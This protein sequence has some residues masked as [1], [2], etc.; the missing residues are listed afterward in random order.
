RHFICY[1]ELLPRVCLK[2]A[3]KGVGVNLKRDAVVP[4][5][6][7]EPLDVQLRESRNPKLAILLDVDEFM[8]QE[9]VR[10]RHVRYHRIAERDG[11]HLGE[12]RQVREAHAR[13]RK[14]TR[15]NSSHVKISYAVFCL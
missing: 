7:Q 15:L 11:G 9:S 5:A 14:S 4:A 10:E 8:E 12:V 13:D 2:L 3:A 6:R 1:G